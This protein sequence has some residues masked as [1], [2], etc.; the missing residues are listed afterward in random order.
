M[1]FL[2]RTLAVVAPHLALSRHVA[3]QK[4]TAFSRFDA[5]KINRNRPMARMNMPA[6]QTGGTTERIRLMNR[7]RDLDDNFSTVRAILTHFVF[8][9]AG[10]LSYQARTGDSA[11]DSSVEAYLRN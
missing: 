3:R 6:E 8:H 4:L 1:N 11:L 9:I 7:A 10:S 2:D 5:A